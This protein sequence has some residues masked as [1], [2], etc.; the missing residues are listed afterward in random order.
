[1]T[2]NRRS[3]SAAWSTATPTTTSPASGTHSRRITNCCTTWVS[4]EKSKRSLLKPNFFMNP[5]L[6]FIRPFL[7]YSKS[8]VQLHI[9]ATLIF[10]SNWW[11]FGQNNQ[12]DILTYFLL[13]MKFNKP[14]T[15]IEQLKSIYLILIRWGQSL[16]S[17][18]LLMTFCYVITLHTNSLFKF[19]VFQIPNY[20]LW[21]EGRAFTSTFSI[22]ALSAC[23]CT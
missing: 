5:K 12:S 20:L 17:I 7:F 6:E 14:F 10:L 11:D 22:D 15:M 23:E 3:S 18:E 13:P 1:M 8:T 19:Q 21:I 2:F 9:T 16:T 4:L